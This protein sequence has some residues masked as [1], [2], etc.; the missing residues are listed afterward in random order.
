MHFIALGN[1]LLVIREAA[2]TDEKVS[3]AFSWDTGWNQWTEGCCSQQIFNVDEIGLLLGEKHCWDFCC[4]KEKSILEFQITHEAFILLLDSSTANSF[5]LNFCLCAI[6]KS[7]G[8][9]KRL[10]RFFFQW[11]GNFLFRLI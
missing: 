10:Q 8:I 2:S 7:H 1:L 9:Y 6:G 3:C 11:Y 5:T 4:P